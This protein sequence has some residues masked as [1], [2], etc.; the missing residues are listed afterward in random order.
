MPLG[1]SCILNRYN[2]FSPHL[3]GSLHFSKV[4]SFYFIFQTPIPSSLNYFPFPKF[5]YFV[6]LM[7]FT[8]QKL[9]LCPGILTF[10][11]TKYNLPSNELHKGYKGENQSI[12]SQRDTG[13]LSEELL[14]FSYFQRQHAHLMNYVLINFYYVSRRFRGYFKLS[15]I[16]IAIEF[17]L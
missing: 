9:W 10:F 12:R 8:L 16:F 4:S 2:S 14:D 3:C 6:F 13:Y 15:L 5:F 17:A 7:C 11:S 1:V